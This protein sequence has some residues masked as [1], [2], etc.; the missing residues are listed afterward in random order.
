MQK[1][2]LAS[3]IIFDE[4][5]RDFGR[6]LVFGLFNERRNAYRCV[7]KQMTDTHEGIPYIPHVTVVEVLDEGCNGN[8]WPECTANAGL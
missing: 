8:D 1:F 6:E 2:Y 5:N 3:A 4:N 7:S